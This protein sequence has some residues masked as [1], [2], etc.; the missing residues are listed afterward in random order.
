MCVSERVMAYTWYFP[1]MKFPIIKIIK[2]ARG[3]GMTQI[4]FLAYV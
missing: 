3:E 1:L 2:V 4:Q